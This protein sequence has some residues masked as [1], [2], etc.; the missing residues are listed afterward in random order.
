MRVKGMILASSAAAALA[1]AAGTA[2]A[3]PLGWYGAVDAGWTK[4][5]SVAAVS[6]GGTGTGYEF[7]L[8][9]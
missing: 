2:S 1:M 3:D 6:N 5:N 7:E 9:R 8:Y 4:A